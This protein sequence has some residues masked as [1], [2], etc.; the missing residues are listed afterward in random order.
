MLKEKDTMLKQTFNNNTSQ[1][2]RR[3]QVGA[4]N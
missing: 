3:Q 1:K 2:E 4:D